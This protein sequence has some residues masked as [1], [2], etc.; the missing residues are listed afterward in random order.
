MRWG[1]LELARTQELLQRYLPPP[2]AVIVDAGGGSGVYA[3]WLARLGYEVHLIDPVP[4]HVE[5]ARAASAR[6]T[7]HPV[8]SIRLGDARRLELP[9]QSVDAVLLL[10][11]L[12]H[13]T[14]LKTAVAK[15]VS[16]AG[17]IFS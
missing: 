17:A 4:K 9:D 12:Y 7:D 11:P 10:G 1:Q 16:P 3:G 8:A 14:E 15:S 6:Q 5:Q 2:S 13:L